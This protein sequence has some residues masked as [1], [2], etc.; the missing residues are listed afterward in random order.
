MQS[1]EVMTRIELSGVL[2]KTFGRVHHRVIRTTQEAGVALAATIPGFERFMIDSKEK[3]LTF[4]VFKGK[5]NIGADDLGYPV[6]GEIIR[7]APVIEGSKKA[8]LLQTILGTV[9]VAASIWMPGLSIAASNMM[10]AVGAS[11][12]TGGVIQML[13]PQLGGL[14]SKES[15]DNK[16]SYAFGGVTNTTSQGYPVPLLYG[17][18]R[19]GGA[20]ISAGIYIEDKM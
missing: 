2:A 20:I 19:I 3:G 10:F 12:A 13:S 16:A 7:I 15:P 9:I 1:K 5:K 14:A 18:R 6:T 4:A 8:G 11:M 17:K